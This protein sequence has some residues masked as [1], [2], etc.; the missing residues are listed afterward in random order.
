MGTRQTQCC[1]EFTVQLGQM[2]KL[3]AYLNMLEEAEKRDHRRLG[4]ELDLFHMQEEAVGSIFWHPRGWSLY[5][6]IEAHVRRRLED[7]DYKEVKTP[8]L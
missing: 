6:E 2:K 7:G 8:Q 3:K 4:R 1:S 5:R